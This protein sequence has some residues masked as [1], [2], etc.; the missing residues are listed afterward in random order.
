MA[1]KEDQT[2]FSKDCVP[3]GFI[4]SDPDHLNGL[5]IQVLYNHWIGRQQ[6]KLSPFVIL[7]AI[8]QHQMTVKKSAKAMGK[9]KMEYMEVSSSD[10]E[11]RSEDG[12]EQEEEDQ[13]EVGNDQGD[14]EDVDDAVDDEEEETSPAPK[15]EPPIGKTKKYQPS[16]KLDSLPNA[17]AGP[18]K[19]HQSKLT[20][21]NL[22][23]MNREEPA[24]PL[25]TPRKKKPT[26]KKDETL[27]KRPNTRNSA[28]RKPD[29]ELGRSQS[30]KRL[31]SDEK[32]KSTR[33]LARVRLEEPLKVSNFDKT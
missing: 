24:A 32:R 3:E 27:M 28:K 15:Y 17:A 33:K 4:L 13:G 25:S 16:T 7:N 2:V 11:V 8:P 31:R 30:P 1:A 5:Q 29:E 22:K 18:S 21:K 12:G 9:R 6:K 14:W 10:E 19:I 20:L 26:K 23:R